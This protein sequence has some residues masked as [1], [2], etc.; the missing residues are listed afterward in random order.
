MNWY[1]DDPDGSLHRLDRGYSLPAHDFVLVR[2]D[3]TL[4]PLVIIPTLEK[5]ALGT[6]Y[7]E[8]SVRFTDALRES[9]LLI[10]AGNSLRD[11]HIR[12][13][14][15]ARMGAL[16]VLLVSPSATARRS[17]LRLPDCVHAIDAG[18]SEFLAIAGN[19]LVELGRTHQTLGPADP[20]NR[21]AIEA[22][23]AS[24]SQD[25]LDES[26]IRQDSDLYRLWTASRSPATAE[27]TQAVRQLASHLHPAVT[28]RLERLLREDQATH[29]RVACVTALTQRQ[30][31]AAPRYSVTRSQMNSHHR[32]SSN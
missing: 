19:K 17:A 32:C 31:M 22:F 13:Y 6:P 21:S 23:V 10:V 28:R 9:R 11:R 25:T 20:A 8:L 12:D 14:I 15:R 4:R 16:N 30:P 24:L 26:A 27:R 5:E 29:V 1:V 18:F 7:V 3:Q 2:R